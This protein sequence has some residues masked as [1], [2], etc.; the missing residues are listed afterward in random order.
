MKNEVLYWKIDDE[1]D[2]SDEEKREIYFNEL[3]VIEDEERWQ[4]EQI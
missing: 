2:L 1:N 3:D 4:D